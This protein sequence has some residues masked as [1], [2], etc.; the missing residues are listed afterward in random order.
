MKLP[1]SLLSLV[2]AFSV[3]LSACGGGGG[4]AAGPTTPPS[5]DTG[6]EGAGGVTDPVTGQPVTK[7]TVINPNVSGKFYFQAPGKYVELDLATG[8]E[9]VLRKSGM[10]LGIS[11]D[12]TEMVM[13]DRFSP[14]RAVGDYREELIIFDRQGAAK[15]RFLRDEGFSGSPIFSPDK[16][17]IISEW[18][19]TD[20][21][22][23]VNTAIGTVFSRSG[24]VLK[25]Y[26]GYSSYAFFADG[27]LLMA[28]GDSVFVA[29]ADLGNPVLLKAFPGDKPRG[30][31]ISP[32][33]T[34]IALSLYGPGIDSTSVVQYPHVWMMNSDGTNARQL[35]TSNSNDD[36]GDFSP[37]GKSMIVSQGIS[38]AAI[39]PGY[40]FAGCPEAYLIPLNASAVIN[41]T[42][43]NIA[44]AQKLV[45]RTDSG[46][47][48]EKLCTFSQPSWRANSS[49]TSTLGTA[50]NGAGANRGLIGTLWYRF[51]GDIFKT[52][53]PSG[54]VF[55]LP[56]NNGADI[57]VSADGQEIAFY[58]R[59]RPV[60]PS[61]EA[62][63]ITNTQG[64]QIAGFEKLSSFSGQAK[65]SPDKTK[66]A[67]EWHSIDLG[68]AGGTPVVTVFSRTGTILQ[69]FVDA[70]SWAWLPDGRLVLVSFDKVY[71]TT[72]PG[73]RTTTL[74]K[75]LTDYVS[76]IV[77][78]PDGGKIA[79]SMNENTWL[80]N[81]DGTGL[82]KMNLSDRDFY[83]GDFSP[84]GKFLLL[85]SG[86]SA[87]ETWVVPLD[88]EKVPVGYGGIVPTSAYR[89]L[90]SDGKPVYP[91]GRVSWRK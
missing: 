57:S 20:F 12:G 10:G 18:S 42:A 72:A 38:Y 7:L 89:L 13:T 35:T 63:V 45:S 11:L 74:V 53:L 62:L 49:L 70:N 87:Y 55:Q 21:G 2:L 61:D 34:K 71:V 90:Q 68:D 8:T 77:V 29:S 43:N 24:A 41:L 54:Q 75:T 91:S 32:D 80:M 25:R 15:T 37:D 23:P 78:S 6:G 82:K 44:P 86:D 5:A 50:A 64:T 31:K 65:L 4:S 56:K 79:F 14:L 16:T 1:T 58:D 73:A 52:T 19:S 27:R 60:D 51:A 3:F 85:Q 36:V 66:I 88:G 39:G 9:T 17:K 40:V 47:V 33:G 67:I 83:P 28:K 81:V 26:V 59:F 22:D 30:L 84:D 46:D 69:R 76:G 48:R